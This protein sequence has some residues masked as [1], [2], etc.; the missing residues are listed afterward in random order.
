MWLWN[1]RGSC[2]VDPDVDT[3]SQCSAIDITGQ[4]FPVVKGSPAHCRVFLVSSFWM[5]GTPYYWA[6]RMKNVSRL[7]NIPCVTKSLPAENHWYDRET[8]KTVS[9]GVMQ[10]TTCTIML[11]V[12]SS[13]RGHVHTRYSVNTCQ[14]NKSNFKPWVQIWF[15]KKEMENEKQGEEPWDAPICQ[16]QGGK[17]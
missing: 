12:L 17:E 13:S 16:E 7:P 15:S 2:T 5:P 11:S 10:C 8:V 14:M 9:F 3:G 1:S 6:V 4:I